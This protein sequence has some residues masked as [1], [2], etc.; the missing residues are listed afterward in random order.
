MIMNGTYIPRHSFPQLPWGTL[1]N[2]TFIKTQHGN[3]LLTGGWWGIAR[4]IHYTADLIMAFAW[5]FI[6][7][8]ETII[9]FFYPIFF[10]IVLIHRVSRDMHRCARKYGKDW[11]EYCK[12]VPYI[13]IPGIY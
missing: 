12:K 11:E 8:F 7:G 13:F 9:P 6:T 3:L 1:E 10:V 4:K 5:A 2:P